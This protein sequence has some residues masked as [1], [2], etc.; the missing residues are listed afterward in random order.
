MLPLFGGPG[1]TRY[2]VTFHHCTT[3]SSRAEAR[4]RGAYRFGAPFALGAF[5]RR[6]VSRRG[7]AGPR[8]QPR[9]AVPQPRRDRD[10][11]P[12]PITV[13]DP[14]LVAEPKAGRSDRGLR[15]ADQGS[16]Q[17]RHGGWIEGPRSV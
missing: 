4:R 3:S 15:D 10:A 1:F 17:D 14:I 8:G 12:E 13:A 7:S 2:C 5:R 6:G 11:K 16:E 9:N